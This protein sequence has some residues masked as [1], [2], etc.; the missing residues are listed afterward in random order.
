M[1][2]NDIEKIEDI[3]L[4]ADSNQFQLHL[5]QLGLPDENIIAST[6]ERSVIRISLPALIN[7]IPL[8]D[9]K[10]AK[11][12][13]KVVAAT[14]IGLFDA[15]LN[16]VWNE[17]IINLRNKVCVY[18]IDLF[19]DAAV[20][21]SNRA[22]Y[23]NESHLDG[24]KD[25][26]LLVTCRD[27]E[28]ISDF[29]Y[30]KISHILTMR[31]KIAA[32]HPNVEVIGGH[33][34]LGWIQTCI[35]DV[36]KDSP[37]QSSINFSL[38]ITNLKAAKTIINE[39]EKTSITMELKKLS[40]THIHNLLITLFGLFV[41]EKTDQIL[42]K[43]ISLIAPDVWKYSSDRIKF[44]IGLRIDGFRSNLQ[45]IKVQHAIEFLDTV[46]GRSYESL[47]TKVATLEKIAQR[48]LDAHNGHDNF[49]TEPP[50]M[51]EILAYCKTSNDLPKENLETLVQVV[52]LCRI[53]R[54]LNYCQGVSPRGKEL[55]N[56]FFTLLND[57][58]IIVFI[59]CLYDTSIN[60]KLKNEICQEHFLSILQLLKP[61]AVSERI[62]EI[63][64][65]LISNS[66]RAYSV[67]KSPHYEQLIQ[68]LFE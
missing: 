27:L 41:D 55:Y 48:L 36:I 16:Y 17:V 68:P 21:G 64:E 43:N 23:V 67:L 19:F 56:S 11:Y 49:Y 18:G 29:I 61:I 28:L 51:E 25:N 45:I 54:G 9:R 60:F 20:G 14:A 59:K 33:E 10:D 34:L 57:D 65:H 2:N 53:G 26:T 42:R 12:L 3:K 32:S 13:S 66:T 24:I 58:G 37:S 7:T 40:T 15:A 35:K 1:E 50:I 46:D 44:T 22:S 4:A 38:L 30:L 63:L 47:P 39:S 5:R 52:T 8:E 31:N 6:D 62:Q